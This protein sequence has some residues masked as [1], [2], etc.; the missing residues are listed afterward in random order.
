MDENDIRP[1]LSE[2]IEALVRRELGPF[3]VERV[4]VLDSEDHYGDPAILVLV[5]YC[6]ADADPDPNVTSALITKLNDLL[7]ARKER[8]FGYI[9]HRVPEPARRIARK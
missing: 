3:G 8:R 7:F 1:D 2:A 4:E 9:E 6:D 5:H